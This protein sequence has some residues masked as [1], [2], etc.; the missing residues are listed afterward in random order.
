MRVIKKIVKSYATTTTATPIFTAPSK[1]SNKLSAKGIV[2]LS[3]S[4][5]SIFELFILCLVDGFNLIHEFKIYCVT[6]LSA[7]IPQIGKI[8]F[9]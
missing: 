8:N 5:I 2:S 3:C 1:V 6:L 7:S 9:T 4:F